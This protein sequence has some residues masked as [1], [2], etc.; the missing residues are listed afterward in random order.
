MDHLRFLMRD[1]LRKSDSIYPCFETFVDPDLHFR[2]V[3]PKER[4]LNLPTTF[5]ASSG[6]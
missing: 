4:S 5:L 6:D 1:A 3:E 2:L